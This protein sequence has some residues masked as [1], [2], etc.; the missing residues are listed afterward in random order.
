M[1]AGLKSRSCRTPQYSPPAHLI[2]LTEN[3][4]IARYAWLNPD[5]DHKATLSEIGV[6]KFCLSTAWS[7]AQASARDGADS[8]AIFDCAN[9]IDVDEHTSP[10]KRRAQ[11]DQPRAE[12][13]YYV[14]AAIASRSSHL[15]SSPTGSS[16][17]PR[18][19]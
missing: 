9:P 12:V 18:V 3:R 2:K 4:E 13:R 14:T 19:H 10:L 8:S 7:I 5:A 6:L 11:R 15:Q 16:Y 17:A 1:E